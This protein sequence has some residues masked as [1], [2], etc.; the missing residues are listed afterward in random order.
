MDISTLVPLDTIA[1]SMLHPV[2]K[3]PLGILVTVAGP[4]HPVTIA[5][6][7][8]QAD[9]H[10]TA[11]TLGKPRGFD[12]AT[13]DVLDELVARTLGWTNVEFGGAPLECT[14][15]NV[16]NLYANPKYAWFR[17]QITRSLG[18]NSR[19]FQS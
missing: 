9:A 1:V 2:T 10:Y 14:P 4:A 5:L 11:G 18:D 3:D 13:G 6:D 16:R 19:F 8:A 15:E 12:A 17:G 7:R